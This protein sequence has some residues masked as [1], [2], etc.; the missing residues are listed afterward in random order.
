METQ[1]LNQCYKLLQGLARRAYV[2]SNCIEGTE[3]AKN[4]LRGTY[5][6]TR[7]IEGK[8]Y[9]NLLLIDR[10]VASIREV[11]KCKE[12]SMPQIIRKLRDKML[13]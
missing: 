1:D 2:R 7:I 9:D 5:D 8:N 13:K 3:A 12:L 11:I 6:D 10:D 4:Y